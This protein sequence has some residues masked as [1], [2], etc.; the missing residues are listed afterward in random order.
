[1]KPL[2]VNS[3]GRPACKGVIGRVTPLCGLRNG[4]PYFYPGRQWDAVMQLKRSWSL[5]T[6]PVSPQLPSQHETRLPAELPFP[7][8]YP[9]PPVDLFHLV[10]Q[11]VPEL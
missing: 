4:D 5:I 3:E 11:Q 2:R 7:S 9:M 8:I 6:R 1:M 10:A